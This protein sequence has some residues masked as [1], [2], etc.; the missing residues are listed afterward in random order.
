MCVS[1]TNVRTKSPAATM[2]TSDRATCPA[3]SRLPSPKRGSPAIARPCSFKPSFGSTPAARRAG[4]VPK[5][6]AVNTATVSVNASTRQSSDRFRYTVLVAVD[7][8]PTRTWLPQSAN[9]SPTAAPAPDNSRLSISSCPA[10]RQRDAPRAS[11][12]LSS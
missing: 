2:S 1:D 4:A 5:S 7:S 10:S 12:T 11:R 8:C 6:T 9:R 3:T